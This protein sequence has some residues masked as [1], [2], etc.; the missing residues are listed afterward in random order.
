MSAAELLDE[1]EATVGA[2][3]LPWLAVL[4]LAALPLRLLQ[5]HFLLRL[6]ELG[7]QAATFGRHLGTLSAL[8]A[9]AT[10]MWV[11]G[12]AVYARACSVFCGVGGDGAG[13]LAAGAARSVLRVPAG[14]FLALL[15]LTL[16]C[17]A[18]LLLGGWTLLALPLPIL[19]AGVAA[20]CHPY[21]GPGLWQPLA[22][23]F[24]HLRGTRHLVAAMAVLALGWLVAW[25]NLMALFAFA[26]WCASALG[27]FDVGRWQVLVS[28]R[29]PGFLVWT[30]TGATL[31]VEPFWLAT[32]AAFVARARQRSRGGDLAY[33]VDRLLAGEA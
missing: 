8:L 13:G 3:A 30:A 33:R 6:V 24:A 11:W 25:V 29:N 7:D 31:L 17:E 20:A 9:V 15:Y 28:P 23:L 14:S 27:G 16:L 1:A 32:C 2:V 4:W 10:V 21:L 22:G 12:R 26:L 19:L 18:M 5:A